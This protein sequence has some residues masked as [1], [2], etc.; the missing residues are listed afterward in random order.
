LDNALQVFVDGESVGF[1]TERD[2]TADDLL[3]QV[4]TAL[5]VTAGTNVMI[6]QEITIE[7]TRAPSSENI[8]SR[9]DI[10]PIILSNVTFLAEGFMISVDGVDMG[11]LRSREAANTVLDN[12][13]SRGLPPGAELVQ[14]ASFTQNVVVEGRFMHEDNFESSE[15]LLMRLGQEQSGTQ[16]YIVQPGDSMSAIAARFNMALEALFE[17]NPNISPVNPNISPGQSINVAYT[18][19]LLSV[20]TVELSVATEDEPYGSEIIENRTRPSTFRN[21][22]QQGQPG[23]V[24]RTTHITRVNGIIVETEIINE[25]IVQPPVN[26]IVEVG[27]RS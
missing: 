16:A 9:P 15:V 25:N 21:V 1:I 22:I 2:A 4:T 19:P 23:V 18:S 24:E 26:E 10:I 27:T 11:V 14:P 6:D 13:I 17:A 8:L 3:S 5:A 20:R 7:A 12:L